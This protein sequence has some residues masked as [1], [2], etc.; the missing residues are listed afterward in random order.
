MKSPLVG[1][2]KTPDRQS[3]SP[4]VTLSPPISLA[5][6]ISHQA[7]RS[8]KIP[9][10]FVIRNTSFLSRTM[11]ARISSHG[12]RGVAASYSRHRRHPRNN[13]TSS[14]STL[15]S[16]PWNTKVQTL[17]AKEVSTHPTMVS[18]QHLS[19]KGKKIPGFCL[20]R[21]THSQGRSTL[22]SAPRT[23]CL[24]I[25][26]NRST[27]HQ[28]RSTLDSVPR[29]S[30][31]QVWDCVSTPP[32]GQVDTLRKDSILRW[33]FATCQPRATGHQPRIVCPCTQRVSLES[34]R[35]KRSL[36]GPPSYQ[37]T[38]LTLRAS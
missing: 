24:Q 16:K 10:L 22:D 5:C 25:W 11:S 27:Q 4:R 21:S 26:D 9:F 20:L 33:M 7:S 19:I 34:F 30:F 31:S 28:S 35:Y 32:P 14:N 37:E 1:N 15:A 29:T 3:V 17:F 13:S 2:K 8:R 36:F 18:T 6:W 12:R 38:Q 23:T